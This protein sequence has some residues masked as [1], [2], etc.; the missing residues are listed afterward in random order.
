[1]TTPTSRRL[2]LMVDRALPPERLPGLATDAERLG[3]DELWL[4]EDLG[5][6]GA[7]AT[8]GTALAVTT[9][10]HVGIGII[11]APL[12]NP[13]VL[14][15]EL[16]AL[17]RLNPGRLIAGIG[18]GV[19]EWMAR[20]GV[21]TPSPLALLEETFVA[22]RT[23][24]AGEELTLDGR[25]VHVR[26]TRLVHP[27]ARVPPLIAGVK[28]P[29]S[30]ELAGR[31]ADGTLLA[32]GSGAAHIVEAHAAAARGGGGSGYEVSIFVHLAI[33]DD[34]ARA[35]T[36]VVPAAADAA[37]FLGIPID[38]A[39]VAAGSPAD[40][41][42][43]VTALWDAGAASVIVRPV[44]DDPIGQFERLVAALSPRG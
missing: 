14:A 43:T 30:L 10:L 6:A 41:A 12:R 1:M 7:I 22:V 31:I 33:D 9:R 26:D 4:V 3:A 23:L 32:E 27:P 28:G 42:A 19:T 40:A 5:W 36:L 2:G 39:T 8:I 20:I 15:M 25:A 21:S 38:E 44:G 11:P 16:A 29:K 35:R 17:E 13:A 24:L 34:P 18:H 37:S